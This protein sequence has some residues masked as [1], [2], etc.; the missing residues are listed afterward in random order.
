MSQLEAARK[1]RDVLLRREAQAKTLTEK[2]EAKERLDAMRKHI[3]FLHRQAREV[4]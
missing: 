2:K 1:C 4:A 3:S